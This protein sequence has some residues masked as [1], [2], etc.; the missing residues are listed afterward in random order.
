[1]IIK[2][3]E[4]SEKSQTFDNVTNSGFKHTYPGY[5]Y[6]VS[7]NIDF[8]PRKRGRP[9]KVIQSTGGTEHDRSICTPVI[10]KRERKIDDVIEVDIE[11]PSIVQPPLTEVGTVHS[12]MFQMPDV[13]QKRTAL[14]PDTMHTNTIQTPDI[15][16]YAKYKGKEKVDER[17][18]NVWKHNLSLSDKELENYTLGAEPYVSNVGA[19]RF[20]ICLMA[21]DVTGVAAFILCDREVETVIGK[22][23]FDVIADQEMY[24]ST[25]SMHKSESI[26]P[27]VQICESK[28]PDTGKSATSNPLKRLNDGT[29]ISITD[30]DEHSHVD[31]N[32]KQPKPITLKHIKKEKV[33]KIINF[34][35]HLCQ[36]VAYSEVTLLK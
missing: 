13:L 30:L 25:Y 20:R 19:T 4:Q 1:M 24:S 18:E 6:S 22:T 23:V 34:K 5:A 8:I 2:M 27:S 7:S 3:N 10:K 16:H 26:T 29:V 31:D 33:I 9:R 35:I 28:T 17:K 14:L 21:E 11:D 12:N 32:E 15:P 36:K